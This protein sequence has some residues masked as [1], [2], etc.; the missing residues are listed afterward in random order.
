[1]QTHLIFTGSDDQTGLVTQLDCP[2]RHA[3]ALTSLAARRHSRGDS[4]TRCDLETGLLLADRRCRVSPRPEPIDLVLRAE[5][6]RLLGHA[7]AAS[8][9]LEAALAIDPDDLLTNRKLMAFGTPSQQKYAALQIL[10]CE[11]EPTML[12]RAL[13]VM[14]EH[15]LAAVARARIVDGDIHGWIA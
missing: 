3:A 6:L 9:D 14:P 7:D 11:H 5:F 15:G 4:V 10:E 13:R 8:A 12:V 1:M 2:S